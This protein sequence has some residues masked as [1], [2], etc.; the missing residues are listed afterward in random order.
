MTSQPRYEH[1]YQPVV[2]SLSSFVAMGLR[3]K[4]KFITRENLD[5]IAQQLHEADS[6][7]QNA[8]ALVAEYKAVLAI[9]GVREMLL[10]AIHKHKSAER[11]SDA[12]S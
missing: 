11:E 9:P 4:R 8:F 7:C 3:Q 6:L 5:R 12:R 2:E 10:E 1:P